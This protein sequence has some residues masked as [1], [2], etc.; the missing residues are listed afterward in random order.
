LFSALGQALQDFL[1]KGFFTV[2][3]LKW[4]PRISMNLGYSRW[5]KMRFRDLC[6]CAGFA[7]RRSNEVRKS[8]LA[9]LEFLGERAHIIAVFRRNLA[10]DPMQFVDDRVVSAWFGFSFFHGFVGVLQGCTS[11]ALCIRWIREVF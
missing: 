10:F 1:R 2:T 11:Q 7:S 5:G 9:I 3:A 6:A 4:R 8:P